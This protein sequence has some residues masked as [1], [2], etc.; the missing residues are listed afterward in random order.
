[1]RLLYRA[2]QRDTCTVRSQPVCFVCKRP[3]ALTAFMKVGTRYESKKI[4]LWTNGWIDET[5]DFVRF[6]SISVIFS[7][8]A[9]YMTLKAV[10]SHLPCKERTITIVVYELK[11]V[12]FHSF[13]CKKEVPHN[14]P[15]E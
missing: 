14:L 1:M 4:P 8:F 13:S 12:F 5:K 15:L 6:D 11:R 3:N 2:G 7:Q 9:G 10:W